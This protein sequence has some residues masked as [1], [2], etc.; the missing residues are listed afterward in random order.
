VLQQSGSLS[1]ASLN[2]V[3]VIEDQYLDGGTTPTAE[4]GLTQW[5]DSVGTFSVSIDQNDGG[6]LSTETESGSYSVD[7]LTG[8]VTLS[9]AGAGD[10]PPVFYLVGPN[11]AFLVGTGGSADFGTLTPQTGSDFT[12]TSLSGLYLGGSQQPVTWNVDTEVDS[13]T[14]DDGTVTG[15]DDKNTSSGPSTGAINA[16]YVV[17]SNGRVVVS[18][19]GV[20]QVILYIISPSQFV[21]MDA[22]SGDDNPRLTDFHQ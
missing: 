19:S 20:Q 15:T 10:H 12:N 17:S 14:L 4:V 8:R 11:Q 13:L 6:T 5:D 3:S 2:G 9:G 18:Q 7:S 21:A 1:S 22:G 16:T